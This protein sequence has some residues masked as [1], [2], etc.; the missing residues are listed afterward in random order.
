[1][2]R[3]QRRAAA[4]QASSHPPAGPATAGVPAS[5]TDF[6]AVGLKLHQAGQLAEAEVCYRRV[7]AAQPNHADALHLLGV[8]AHQLGRSDLA[9]ELI[10]QAIQWNGQAA[11]YFSNLG[12]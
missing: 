11:N 8:V 2:N 10:R 12:I 4:K 5:A 3:K 7:L 6:L 9:V 1:M